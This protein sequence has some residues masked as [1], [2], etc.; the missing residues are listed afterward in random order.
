MMPR[1]IYSNFTALF[2]LVIF[3]HNASP[4]YTLSLINNV[5]VFYLLKYDLNVA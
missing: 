5:C 1:L 2:A 4:F 3:M